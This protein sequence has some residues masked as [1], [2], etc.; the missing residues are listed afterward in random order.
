MKGN[1]AR[2]PI[3]GEAAG[4][5]YVALPPREGGDRAPLVVAWHMM[6]PPRSEAAMAA[7]LPLTGVD[8]W[9]VYVGLPMFGARAPSGGPEQ[10]MRLAADDYVLNLFG[11][12]VEQAASEA[13]EAVAALQKQLP[14]EEGPIGVVGGSAG[15]AVALLILAESDLPVAAAA[16]LNP[17]AHVAPVLTAGERTYGMTYSWSDESR[18]V[19]DRLDFVARAADIGKREPQPPVLLV[20]GAR[21]EP[22]MRDAVEGLRDALLGQYT[23]P[24]RVGFVS[25]P[26]L[27]HALAEEPGMEPAPQTP[28]AKQ[29]DEAVADWFRRHLA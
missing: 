15:G 18:A 23:E 25:V 9:R 22:E 11:P 29:V 19:A 6:D 24:D 21:D 5:P 20:S 28:G 14:I 26:E 12:V 2:S 8:A 17:V 27:A 7:A 10:I 4:V 13:P 3:S 16:L 1:G